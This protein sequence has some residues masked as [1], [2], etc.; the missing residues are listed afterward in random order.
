[1]PYPTLKCK[2]YPIAKGEN[3]DNCDKIFIFNTYLLHME[4]SLRYFHW[5]FCLDPQG[6]ALDSSK[7][8]GV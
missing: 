6:R 4:C 3:M 8:W 7:H 2:F 5:R 1:M